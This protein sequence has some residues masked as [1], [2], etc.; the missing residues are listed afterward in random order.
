MPMQLVDRLT[1]LTKT[2]IIRIIIMKIMIIAW[3]FMMK[4]TNNYRLIH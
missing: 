2:T 4:M 1:N 3:N